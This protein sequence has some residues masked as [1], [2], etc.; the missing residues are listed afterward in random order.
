MQWIS[1]SLYL[2]GIFVKF[3]PCLR[4]SLQCI[5]IQSLIQHTVIRKCT[6]NLRR[7]PQWCPVLGNIRDIS[8]SPRVPAPL[9]SEAQ[10]GNQLINYVLNE[11]EDFDQC[12]SFATSSE[13]M[14]CYNYPASL[15][16]Q[17]EIHIDLS[18]LVIVF[19]NQNENPIEVSC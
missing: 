6:M 17:N 10:I 2:T 18:C 11:H 7:S 9:Y 5:R 4:M 13:I 1:P 12:G 16:N 15:M 14:P 19:G 3:S 8:Q